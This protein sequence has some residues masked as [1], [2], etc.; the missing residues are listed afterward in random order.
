MN[1]RF[2][3]LF[4]PFL[5]LTAL[6]ALACN[7]GGLTA[8]PTPTPIPSP[9]LTPPPTEY[10]VPDEGRFHIEVGTAADYAHFPPS[11]GSH[12]GQIPDWG[13]YRDPVPPEYF[14]HNLEHGGIVILYNCPTACPDSEKVFVTLLNSAP[15]ETTFNEVKILV[16]PNA[17]I[18]S[19]VIALAWGW[20]L[21]LPQTDLDL[22]LGFYNRHVNQGPELAP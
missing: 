18:D 21:D 14:V 17:K 7:F 4:A 22:L 3:R 1:R 13:F 2:L 8:P 9:T 11:S 6:T 19:P 12:Y 20:E 10:A 5:G 16:S 15:A